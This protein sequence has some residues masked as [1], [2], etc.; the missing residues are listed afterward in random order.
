MLRPGL[1]LGRVPGHF[2]LRRH[3]VGLP[4]AP[5]MSRVDIRVA[6]CVVRGVRG[7]LEWA[8]KHG[9]ETQL[10]PP[11]RC[12]APKRKVPLMPSQGGKAPPWSCPACL[13]G[14]FRTCLSSA[15]AFSAGCRKWGRREIPLSEIN[16]YKL[17][18][19]PVADECVG[20]PVTLHVSRI[21]THT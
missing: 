10:S 4:A 15:N 18:V 2:H 21:F 6:R 20:V 5:R 7:A 11:R 13:L 14:L 17:I 12:L 8:R 1:L 19:N 3:Q 16:T 9:S